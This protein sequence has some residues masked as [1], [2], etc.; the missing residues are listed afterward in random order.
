MLTMCE[1]VAPEI[2]QERTKFYKD[3]WKELTGLRT[4]VYTHYGTK[5]SAW[6]VVTGLGVIELR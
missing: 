3:G 2:C 1:N 4:A 5:K 6:D